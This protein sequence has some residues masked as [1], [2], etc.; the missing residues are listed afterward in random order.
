MKKLVLS[1]GAMALFAAT[2]ALSAQYARQP[3]PAA[4]N[5]YALTPSVGVRLRDPN[6]E[7]EGQRMPTPGGPEDRRQPAPPARAR[8]APDADGASVDA[9][10]AALY[11][12]VSHDAST[13]PN[14]ERMRGIF[15]QIGMLI[16]PKNPRSDLFT[17]LDVDGFEQRVKEG[18]AAAKQ[19]G[20]STA[21]FEK[22]VARRAD[23]FGNV[24]QIFSTYES[25]RARP[26][27]R[28]RSS[29]AS[30][31]SSSS[32]TATAGGSLPWPGTRSGP[33]IR[34]RRSTCREPSPRST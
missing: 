24:C 29:G 14:W 30:T 7:A 27:T 10:I 11:G 34:S 26:P 20:E 1:G 9:I 13:E 28:N 8:R 2:L 25:R 15:L 6:A 32:T 12:S 33:T 18:M 4:P 22:E 21:F 3:T 31:A 23:C 16:P 19:K 5:P 17:V